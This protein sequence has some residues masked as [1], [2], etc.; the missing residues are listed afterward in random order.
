MHVSVCL[1]A[2]SYMRQ[3]KKPLKLSKVLEFVLNIVSFNREISDYFQHNH[4]DILHDS[5]FSQG[6]LQKQTSRKID[7]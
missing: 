4:K 7:R 6:S 5:Y 2:S 1:C 3:K